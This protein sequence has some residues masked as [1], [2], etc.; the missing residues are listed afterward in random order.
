MPHAA[1]LAT[2]P[3]INGRGPWPPIDARL[4]VPVAIAWAVLA[5]CVAIPGALVLAAVAAWAAAGAGTTLALAVARWRRVLVAASVALGL[6]ALLLTAAAV[7]APKRSP[8]LLE[9]AAET[10]RFVRVELVLD[11]T[12]SGSSERVRGT[13]VEATVGDARLESIAVPVVVFGWSASGD[14]C[15]LGTTVR[16]SG[17][18]R[19]TDPGD[20]AAFLMFARGSAEVVDAPP[21]YLDW[22]NHVRASFREASGALPGDGGDLLAGLAIGDTSAVSE[23]LNQAM[24]DTALSHLTAVSGANCAV[25]VGIMMA[26]GAAAG[27]SR[28]ARIGAALLTLLAFVVLV[29][30]EASVVRAA[31]MA[32]VVLVSL[33]TGRPVRGV[34]VL[35]LAVAVLLVIDPWWCR[36]FGFVLSV[37]ATAGLLVLAPVLAQALGRWMPTSLALVVAIPLSA[38]LACQ[39]VLILLTP[40]IPVYG[41]LANVLAAPAAPLATVVGLL[42]CVGL[43]VLEPLGGL[44]TGVAWVPSAWIAAVARFCASLPAAQAPWVEG[45][46]GVL[47][48]LGLAVLIVRTA[49]RDRRAAAV[50]AAS[51]VLYV[52]ILAGLDWGRRGGIPDDWQLAACPIGQG[53]AMLVRSVGTVALIDT[54]PDPELLADCLDRL[55][56]DRIDLLVLSHYDLDHVGGAAAV[57]GRVTHAIVANPGTDAGARLVLRELVTSGA[58]V[59]TVQRGATGHLGELRWQVLWPAA[60]VPVEPGNDASVVVA[61][62]GVGECADGCLSSIFLGDLG[63]RA[64]TRLLTLAQPRPVAVVK[65]SHHGS[66]DQSER[67]YERLA[68]RVGLIGVGENRY[69]H[70]SASILDVLHRTGTTVARTDTQ[71]LL[72]VSPR[73]DGSIALWT[74]SDGGSD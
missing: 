66:K 61:F 51:L 50:L 5:V 53:D 19:A 36:S 26:L 40:V 12:V 2:A 14:C 30:P 47:L 8:A 62:D 35:A 10:G 68:A 33:G 57:H 38:Q 63:E 60:S 49:T 27:L 34:P 21:W 37:L 32:T 18:L 46:G 31:T 41:V 71:G 64:Q 3:G 29:T 7:Q 9:E 74:E 72:L 20:G 54:G 24:I 25:V 73:P 65:V 13:I 48:A 67:L 70:P 23:S 52:A 16:V 43:S 15:G 45:A 22:A 44:L 42:A 1:R 6:T 11:Q 56:I 58:R 55:G 4:A 69:G 59:E 28:R 17:T 39:P